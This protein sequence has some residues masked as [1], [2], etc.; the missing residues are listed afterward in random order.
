MNSTAL[1]E[2]W[3]ADST[4]ADDSGDDWAGV[5]VVVRGEAMAAPLQELE[6]TCE[7]SLLAVLVGP[8]VGDLEGTFE[9]AALPEG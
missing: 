2:E 5:R 3:A 7:A 1:G 8:V 9:G 6:V 4:S